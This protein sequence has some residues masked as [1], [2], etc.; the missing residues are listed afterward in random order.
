MLRDP[1][2][3]TLSFLRN[4]RERRAEVQHASL[5]EIYADE[6]LFRCVLQNHMVK[7]F[8]L[9]PA[10]LSA[11]MFT[12]VDFSREHLERAEEQ[13]T[14]VDVIGLQERL[15]DF[16]HD[17]APHRAACRRGGAQ[18]LR[19]VAVS[20]AFATGSPRTMPRRKGSTTSRRRSSTPAAGAYVW[21]QAGQPADTS[22]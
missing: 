1:V 8:S 22:E 5:E 15:P 4:F 12:R 14:T 21:H 18:I 20:M 7:M 6:F 9:T 2:E 17:L 16:C 11:G 13:L 19:P 10:D 3:R